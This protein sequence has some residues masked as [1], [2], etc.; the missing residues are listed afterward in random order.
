MPPGRFWSVFIRTGS[1]AP[2]C[3]GTAAST[4]S[5]RS[6]TGDRRCGCWRGS[7]S[8]AAEGDRRRHPRWP[9]PPLPV[10]RPRRRRRLPA[11]ALPPRPAIP[12]VPAAPVGSPRERGLHPDT[13]AT[14]IRQ[15]NH[16]IDLHADLL[17][18]GGKLKQPAGHAA[19]AKRR[20]RGRGMAAN[21][22][23]RPGQRSRV[24]GTRGPDRARPPRTASTA[25]SIDCEAGGGAAGSA[26]S[27]TPGRCRRF[28]RGRTASRGPRRPC[29]RRNER[30]S[31]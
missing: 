10:H 17:V 25:R 31:R 28:R 6:G 15:P 29:R 8:F 4:T 21:Q 3:P 12:A 22:V 11:P 13:A 27:A 30:R 24:R 1:S 16:S 14:A 9:R 20:G 7:G 23:G 18:L 5:R 26:T 19:P 2:G